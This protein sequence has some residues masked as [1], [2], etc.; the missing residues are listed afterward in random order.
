MTGGQPDDIVTIAASDDR[1]STLVTAVEAAGLGETLSGEGPFTVF[2][3]TNAAFDK[4]PEGKVSEL[5]KPANKAELA[6]VLSYHVVPGKA[7]SAQLAGTRGSIATVQ[8]QQVH[9]DG[10][11]GVTVE[12]ANVVQ[13]DIE[14]SNGV[15]HAIDKVMMPQ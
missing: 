10:T 3:P 5:L 15:I 1:F 14:A 13:A 12:D 11:D 2:A 6:K 9:I 4:L 7:T 8:G